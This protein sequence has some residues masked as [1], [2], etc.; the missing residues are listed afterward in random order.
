MK[1]NVIRSAAINL[2]DKCYEM[3]CAISTLDAIYVAT[4]G[5]LAQEHCENS[6]NC[7]AMVIRGH[8]EDM[9]EQIAR[10][11]KATEVESNE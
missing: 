7:I 5:G 4:L 1:Q 6:L 10:I 8:Y 9:R 3:E 11:L 2:D